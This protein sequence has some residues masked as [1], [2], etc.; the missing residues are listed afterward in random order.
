MV[1][2]LIGCGG[3]VVHGR[4]HTAAN[5]AYSPPLLQQTL[6]DFPHALCLPACLPFDLAVLSLSPFL[7][8]LRGLKHTSPFI[9]QS[10]SVA[11]HQIPDMNATPL[12]C[13]QVLVCT[14]ITVQCRGQHIIHLPCKCT[15][16]NVFFAIAIGGK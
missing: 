12:Q 5:L 15:E 11:L 9:I 1:L 4:V 8:Q 7:Q 13:C 10:T 6:F 3:L 16:Q 2:W 14:L